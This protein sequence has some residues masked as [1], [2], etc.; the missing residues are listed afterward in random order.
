MS[1]VEGRSYNL[2]MPGEE[3][4]RDV[5]SIA[6]GGADAGARL[7]RFLV[8]ALGVSRSQARALLARGAVSLGGRT[9]G[10]ADK[11]LSLPGEGVLEVEPFRRPADQR[12]LAAHEVR[13]L[14]SGPG[15]LVVDKPA[16]WPVHPLSEDETGTLLNAVARLHPEIHGVGDGGLR[17]GVLHRLD[18]DTTGVLLFATEQAAWVR[19]RAAFREHRIEKRYRVIVSGRCPQSLEGSMEADLVVARHR[20]ARVRVVDV[21]SPKARQ[22]RRVRQYIRVLERF[23]QASLLE[24]SIETG[25]LHQIRVTLAHHGHPVLGDA[26]YGDAAA[27]GH[28]APRQMLHAA[29]LRFEEVAAESPDPADF[30]RV[31]SEV[32]R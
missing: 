3:P 23:A 16:G 30:T 9:L 8:D 14:T 2:A 7:D 32:G 26:L 1:W 5:S 6:L 25:F 12:A 27:L 28:G 21:S 19:L 4:A 10:F 11:G 29:K 22:A 18:V 24:V 17:S 20:P 15:W 31:L 13:V